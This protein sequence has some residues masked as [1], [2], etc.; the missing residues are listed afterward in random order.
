VVVLG[1]SIKFL[2]SEARS[3]FVSFNDNDG[4]SATF[5]EKI[6][7]DSYKNPID[8]DWRGLVEEADLFFLG[9]E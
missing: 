3:D 1:E 6:P 4:G 5:V 2:D 9:D 8:L 7:H